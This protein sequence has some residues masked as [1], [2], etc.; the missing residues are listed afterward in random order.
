MHKMLFK[1]SPTLLNPNAIT[2]IGSTFFSPKCTK[3]RLS[4]LPNFLTV[5]ERMG[6]NKGRK[7][8]G[9]KRERRVRTGG[10]ERGAH[11][12]KFSKGGDYGWLQYYLLKRPLGNSAELNLYRGMKM[13]I[14]GR[15]YYKIYDNGS[16]RFGCGGEMANV[17][18]QLTVVT[19]V[20]SRRIDQ[21]PAGN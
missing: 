20:R 16:R 3:C 9:E 12:Q 19:D 13:D 6:E 8:K 10:K 1:R 17:V 15:L 11:P 5:T 7:D 4:A 18:T 2:L 14:N 21:E